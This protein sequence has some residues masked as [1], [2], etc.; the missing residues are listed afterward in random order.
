MILPDTGL[1]RICLCY[2]YK[3][4]SNKNVPN[5]KGYKDCV[6]LKMLEHAKSKWDV[7]LSEWPVDTELC[8]TAST[9]PEPLRDVLVSHNKAMGSWCNY[10]CHFL[11]VQVLVQCKTMYVYIKSH[12]ERHIQILSPVNTLPSLCPGPKNQRP[13]HQI[14]HA[15]KWRL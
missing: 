2:Y 15:S 9:F 7:H 8:I 4:S 11:R 13:K 12:S 3:H 1:L 6:G 14:M 5:F 10:H